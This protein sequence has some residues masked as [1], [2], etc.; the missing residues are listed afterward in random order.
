MGYTL[1]YALQAWYTMLYTTLCAL[2]HT[3]L[4]TTLCALHHTTLYTTKYAVKYAGPPPACPPVRP[5]P[6]PPPPPR[7]ATVQHCPISIILLLSHISL[8]L[9]LSRILIEQ[10][11]HIKIVSFSRSCPLPWNS[12]KMKMALLLLPKTKKALLLLPK[13]KKALLLLPKTKKASIPQEPPPAAAQDEEGPP[14]AAQD[15]E[16]PPAAAV[17]QEIKLALLLLLSPKRW[18]WSSSCCPR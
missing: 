17:A 7:A 12:C 15:E 6:P 9:G 14:A 3:T 5:P 8:N 13:T 2:H 11:K 4:Y 16:G 18:S 1:L 10:S